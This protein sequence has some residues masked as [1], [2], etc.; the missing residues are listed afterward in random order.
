MITLYTGLPGVGKTFYM[1]KLALKTIKQK[2]HIWANWEIKVPPEFYPYFHFFS[3]IDDILKVEDGVIFMDEIWLY[4]N[5]R[6]WSQLPTSWIYK[7]LQHRKDG[8]DVIGSTQNIKRVDTIVREIVARYFEIRRIWKLL[9]IWEYSVDDAN[10]K[11]RHSL[12]LKFGW[13]SKK[14]CNSFSTKIKVTDYFFSP[15]GRFTSAT[16]RY[17]EFLEKKY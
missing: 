17:N 2:R 13:L 8:I 3:T 1:T 16:P 11:R 15:K 10:K 6:S 12:S 14:I 4:F 7:L 5:A 9:F